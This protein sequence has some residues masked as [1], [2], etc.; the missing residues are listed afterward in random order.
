MT[1]PSISSTVTMFAADVHPWTM[2]AL[3]RSPSGG[4]LINVPYSKLSAP[5]PNQS[6]Q[7]SQNLGSL[8]ESVKE[9]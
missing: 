3:P 1:Q 6:F 7:P 9:E 4:Y 2:T 5:G 8:N